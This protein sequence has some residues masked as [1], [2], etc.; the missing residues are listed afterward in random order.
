MD[1]FEAMALLREVVDRGSLSAAG[2]SLRVPVPTLSRKISELEALLGTRLLVRTTRKITLTD[3]GI[4]YLTATRRILDEVEDAEREAVGEFIA[5]K[6]EL[7]VTAP[8]HFGRLH[9]LPVVAEFLMLFAEI[10]VRLLLADRNIRL[11]DDHV[12]LAVRIGRLEDSTMIAT[13]IG[14]MRTVICGSPKLL[15]SLGVLTSPQDLRGLPIVAVDAPMPGSGWRL[16]QAGSAAST[17][18]SV[19][20]RLSVT[21]T[22]AAVQAAIRGVGLAQLLHYQVAEAVEAGKLQI[23]LEKFE[24][25]PAPIH[26]VHAVRGQLPLK[27]RRFLDLAAPRLRRQLDEVA[28]TTRDAGHYRFHR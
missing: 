2:R 23:V 8:L 20:P 12:D 3:A 17:E 10:N 9:V 14:S 24:P 18:V 11:V 5:P 27:M 4:T 6:G 28:S 13:R 7:V 19:V 25:E 26:L 16:Q 1:R 15:A 22:E 21:T